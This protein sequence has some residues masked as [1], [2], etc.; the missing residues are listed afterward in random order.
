MKTNSNI[1]FR[2]A[3]IELHHIF[4]MYDISQPDTFKKY[5]SKSRELCVNYEGKLDQ[6]HQ[7]VLDKRRVQLL[8]N[9]MPDLN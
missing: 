2:K 3:L 7:L 4:E 1:N 9:I 6:F 5:G 8:I